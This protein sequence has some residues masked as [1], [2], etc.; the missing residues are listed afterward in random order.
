MSM[1]TLA[2]GLSAVDSLGVMAPLIHTAGYLAVTAAL[3]VAG[4]R[5]GGAP[6]PPARVDQPERPLVCRVDRRGGRDSPVISAAVFA[7]RRWRSQRS[8]ARQCWYCRSL[9]SLGMTTKFRLT[10]LEHVQH[11]DRGHRRAKLN[12]ED[13]FARSEYLISTAFHSGTFPKLR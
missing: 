4:V 6:H 1:L 5:A 12:R 13:Y 8:A 9:A 3:A 7:A 10:T 2:A 11:D